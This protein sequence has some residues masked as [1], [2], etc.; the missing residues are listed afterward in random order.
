MHGANAENLILEV[1]VGTLV[2]DAETKELIVDLSD[3]NMSYII[4]Y[5]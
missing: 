5:G 2:K 1:P 4:V 3:K